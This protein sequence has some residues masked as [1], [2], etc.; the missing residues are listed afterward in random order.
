MP[1][2][3]GPGRP[4]AGEGFGDDVLGCLLIADGGRHC[5]QAAVAGALVEGGELRQFMS[6]TGI[7]PERQDSLTGTP[8]GQHHTS[9][10]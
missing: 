2:D 5:P 6:H 7:T 4:S 9:Q 3:R 1:R 10:A 8:A